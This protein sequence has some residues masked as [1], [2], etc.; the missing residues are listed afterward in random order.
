MRKQMKNK[1]LVK[2][3]GVL[4]IVGLLIQPGCDHHDPNPCVGQIMTKAGFSIKESLSIVDMDTLLLADTVL[5][6][7]PIVFEA[8]STYASCEW[9]IGTDPRTFN[10]KK[11]VLSFDEPVGRISIRLIAKWTPNKC[12]MRDNGIDT[13]TKYLTIVDRKSNPIFGDYRGADDSSPLDSFDITINHDDFYDRINLIN[14]NQGCYPIDES[15]G[16]R[17]LYTRMGYKT[18]LFYSGFY[19][20]SCDNP[21]G[22]VRITPNGHAAIINYSVGNGSPTQLEMHRTKKRYVGSKIN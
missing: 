17:G 9:S 8:D 19:Y 16:L 3:I 13:V 20:N 5:T 21:Q 7:N 12:F 10:T 15:I 14:I 2:S 4:L 18:L 1:L 11:V 6:F 22:L